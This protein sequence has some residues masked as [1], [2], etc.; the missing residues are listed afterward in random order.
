MTHRALTLLND[1][2]VRAN[3]PTSKPQEIQET[4]LDRKIN[5]LEAELNELKESRQRLDE[6]KEKVGHLDLGFQKTYLR[7]NEVFAGNGVFTQQE[8]NQYFMLSQ[9]AM[10]VHINTL[11]EAGVLTKYKLNGAGRTRF[12]YLIND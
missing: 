9:G 10:S 11:V 1:A 3:S 12:V 2:I 6:V 5:R 7:L 8:A 4:S